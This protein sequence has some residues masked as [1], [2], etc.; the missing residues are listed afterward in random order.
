MTIDRFAAE[1]IQFAKSLSEEA[2]Q[3][4]LELGRA[5]GC[6][7]DDI[8][9]LESILASLKGLEHEALKRHLSTLYLFRR[10]LEQAQNTADSMPA[11]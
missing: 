1:S 3:S 5:L 6:A 7:I 4:S 10:F 2:R 11:A 8:P 9:A